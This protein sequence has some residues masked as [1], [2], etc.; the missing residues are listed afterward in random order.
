MGRWGGVI[1]DFEEDFPSLKNKAWSDINT[2]CRDIEDTCLDK[3]RV[4]E[5]MLRMEE[6][7]PDSSAYWNEGHRDEIM[8]ELGLEE[9]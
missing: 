8:K 3:Q 6:F 7:I 9:K 1:M 5:H 2:I 4:K